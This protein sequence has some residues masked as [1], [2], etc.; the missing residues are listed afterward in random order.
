M[1]KALVSPEKG[2]VQ[3]SGSG[4]GITASSEGFGVY[5]FCKE[6]DL[7]GI[8][9]SG[10]TATVLAGICQL[11]ATA[12]VLQIHL[13][14]TEALPSQTLDLDLIADDE[15]VASI[16]TASTVGETLI[17]M[18]D[19]DGSAVGIN[20]LGTLA[21][22]SDPQVAHADANVYVSLAAGAGGNTTT[23]LTQGKVV[24]YIKVLGS[25]PILD[26]TV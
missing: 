15:K 6:V 24:V 19:L 20:K 23:L 9:P 11:P 1:P 2:L 18:G 3:S 21:G 14:V 8:T 4:F 7:S 26:Y 25:G 5:E 12:I 17:N 22:L 16:G 10:T 13:M